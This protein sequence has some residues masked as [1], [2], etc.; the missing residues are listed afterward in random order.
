MLMIEKMKELISE[1]T[2]NERVI[3]DLDLEANLITD[4]GLDSLQFINMLLALEDEY[5]LDI[6]FEDFDMEEF[7]IVGKLIAYIEKNK[8]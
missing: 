1:I 2:E 3:D 4:I 5:D 7:F 6:D 8:K